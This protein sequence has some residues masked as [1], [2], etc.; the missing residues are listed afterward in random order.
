[1]KEEKTLQ[2]SYATCSFEEMEETDKALILKAK[3]AARKSYAP[4]SS[5]HVGCAIALEDGTIVTGNNQENA[6]YPCG[7]CAER[8]TLFY[9][10]ANYPNL[11]ILHIAIAAETKGHF[12]SQPLPPCGLCRQS[13]LEAEHIQQTPIRLLMFGEER[14]IILKGM[15]NLLP[16]QFDGG[17]LK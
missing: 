4:Y 1:M 7:C 2:V 17:F 13:L 16:F 12:T 15:E 11:P 8:T 3:E 9:A 5:F 6:S 14:V 10:H